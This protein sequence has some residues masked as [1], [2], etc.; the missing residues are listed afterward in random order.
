MDEKI[1]MVV[2]Y[3]SAKPIEGWIILKSK[4]G[5]MEQIPYTLIDVKVQIEEEEYEEGG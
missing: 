2:K 5:H 1:Q 4:F 3:D